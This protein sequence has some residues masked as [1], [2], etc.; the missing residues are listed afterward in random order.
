MYNYTDLV[1]SEYLKH[2]GDTDTHLRFSAANNIEITA[3]GNKIMRFEGN[4]V[5]LVVNEDSA[6]ID[7]RV[8]SNNIAH[9]LFV[10]GGNDK[11]GIGFSAPENVLTIK[12]TENATES[13]ITQDSDTWGVL[14]ET[15]NYAADRFVGMIAHRN[16]NKEAQTGIWSEIT[17]SGSLMHLGTSADY[18][19]G[20]N[21]KNMTL[22]HDGTVNFPGSITSV[23]TLHVGKDSSASSSVIE[24]GCGSGDYK[25]S[26]FNSSFSTN[27][28]FVSDG[29][30]L[31][32]DDNLS[33]GLSIIS[34]HASGQIRF[35]T[36]G[37]ADGY[38]RLH[39]DDGGNVVMQ[40]G[41]GLYF[42][43]GS[44]TYITEG[45]G[46]TLNFYTGGN[47]TMTLNDH[48]L[49]TGQLRVYDGAQMGG[50][51]Y[52][53]DS[54]N[55]LTL[56]ANEVS[57]DNMRIKANNAIYFD[58]AGG[59][60]VAI[61]GD[62]LGVG[63]NSPSKDIHIQRADCGVACR[64]A[65]S[66]TYWTDYS[67]DFIDCGASTHWDIRM[68]GD[69]DFLF[70]NDGVAKKSSGAGDW[71]NYSDSRLKTNI[72]DLSVDALATLNSLRPVEFNW[73]KEE[74]YNTPKD[75]NGKS[76]GF[77]AQEIESTM[78]QL[79]TEGELPRDDEQREYVDE[80]GMAKST[81]LGHMAS[82]YIKAIQ[83]LTSRIE[84][85]ENA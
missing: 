10:D 33:G 6:D 76:Y 84:A 54:S 14:V 47:N 5:E 70:Y 52:Y 57:G 8:E 25:L 11:I 59:T 13:N 71:A 56:E 66:S 43:G 39:I 82:L 23:G 41:K 44:N 2:D 21:V 73:K 60:V 72:E 17:S 37:Y 36:G 9:M 28:A 62:Y 4:A 81:E 46:D 80:D 65:Y 40:T 50:R 85:L 42:D 55:I 49:I 75:S 15:G 30:T 26:V 24:I 74:L 7:F 27:G 45:S 53:S 69:T 32:A 61:N 29:A 67:Y 18:D 1:I 68:A 35:Y 22:K 31:D 48:L 79:V 38:K 78:P 19:T 58:D 77:I 51:L 64:V 3:G 34:R 63:Q 12:Q 16:A 20:V 83:Q